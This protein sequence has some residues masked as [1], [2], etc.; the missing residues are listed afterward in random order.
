MCCMFKLY[1][2]F[3]MYLQLEI[4]PHI[5]LQLLEIQSCM[6]LGQVA[7]NLVNFCYATQLLTAD[8]SHIYDMFYTYKTYVLYV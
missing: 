6:Q 1:A 7:C 5:L 4:N 3:S 8:Q 2:T